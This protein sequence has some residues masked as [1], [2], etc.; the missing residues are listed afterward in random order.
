MLSKENGLLMPTGHLATAEG[1]VRPSTRGLVKDAHPG[2]QM[3]GIGVFFSI[4]RPTEGL[5]IPRLQ[6][7][8]KAQNPMLA[9]PLK[10]SHLLSLLKG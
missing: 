9:P 1:S 7:Q 6:P 3:L 8:V 10:P 2:R 4:W 5:H